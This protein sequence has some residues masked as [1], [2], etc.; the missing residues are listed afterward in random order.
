ME[1]FA[2][3]TGCRD[4]EIASFYLKGAGNDVAR[5]VNH[6]FD[7]PARPDSTLDPAATSTA[8]ASSSGHGCS[9]SSRSSLKRQ[10]A[11]GGGHQQALL[12]FGCERPSWESSA[13]SSEAEHP[14]RGVS[15]K[16]GAGRTGKFGQHAGARAGAVLSSEWKEIAERCLR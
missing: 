3:A 16:P 12:S 5:A 6:F 14:T 4:P 13:P 7:C 1:L 15:S 9:A 10:R 2:E 8:S 11:S